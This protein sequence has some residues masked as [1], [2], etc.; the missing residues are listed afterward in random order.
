MKERR[1]QRRIVE[2]RLWTS[3]L[4]SRVYDS[5]FTF[6]SI[7]TT[8]KKATAC[9]GK[10]GC[11]GGTARPERA[12]VPGTN[13]Q[14]V[15]CGYPGASEAVVQFRG[16][17]HSMRHSVGIDRFSSAWRSQ[18]P[19]CRPLELVTYRAHGTEAK[20][21]RLGQSKGAPLPLRRSGREGRPAEIGATCGIPLELVA[22]L[23]PLLNHSNRLNGRQQQAINSPTVARSRSTSVNPC[24]HPTAQ[25]MRF[26]F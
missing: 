2:G 12:V 4:P 13:R 22:T 16:L 10:S 15:A 21:T 18:R 7:S 14:A 5:A 19:P 6:L 23:Q 11:A 9:R 1:W 3:Q 8:V 20:T 25:P 17:W 26:P 24:R